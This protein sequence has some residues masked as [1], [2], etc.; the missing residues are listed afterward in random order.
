ML[1]PTPSTLTEMPMSGGVAFGRAEVTARA[2]AAAVA[3]AAAEEAREERRVAVLM[4][5]CGCVAG[6]SEWE[7]GGLGE[8][9]GSGG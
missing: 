3:A 9:D 7:C 5:E 2:A 4:G 8:D 1:T 6:L